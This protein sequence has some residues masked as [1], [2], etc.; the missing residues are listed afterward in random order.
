MVQMGQPHFSTMYTLPSPANRSR[1]SSG[2]S[3]P[4]SFIS[5]MEIRGPITPHIPPPEALPFLYLCE[6]SKRERKGE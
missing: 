2:Q 6:R 5:I 3:T 1:F 4:Y